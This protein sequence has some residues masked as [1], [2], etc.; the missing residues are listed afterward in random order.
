MILPSIDRIQ[1]GSPL[2]PPPAPLVPFGLYKNPPLVC[3]FRCCCCS[4]SS[5]LARSLAHLLTCL[6]AS[7]AH[8]LTCSLAHVLTRSLLSP[9]P[10]S[11]TPPSPAQLSSLPSRTRTSTNTHTH[12]HVL[13]AA[14]HYQLSVPGLRDPN[15]E[16][17]LAVHLGLVLL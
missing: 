9:T 11:S 13:P 7:L 2:T 16:L 4:S 6:P 5:S 17:V 8:L 3:R 15:V 14:P 10:P 1:A 12:H